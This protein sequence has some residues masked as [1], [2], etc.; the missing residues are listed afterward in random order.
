MVELRLSAEKVLG[1]LTLG[2]EN[3][4]VANGLNSF[5]GYMKVQSGIGTTAA[6]QS[7]IKGYANTAA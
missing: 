2:A 5:S 6:E 3:S 4:A 7:K 1:L